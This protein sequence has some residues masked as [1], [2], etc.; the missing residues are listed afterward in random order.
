MTR[1]DRGASLCN[2]YHGSMGSWAA[3]SSSSESDPSQKRLSRAPVVYAQN[4]AM[5]RNKIATQA[6]TMPTIAPVERP[7]PPSSL[8][9]ASEISISLELGPGM[10]MGLETPDIGPEVGASVAGTTGVGTSIGAA[11]GRGGTVGT[12]AA[13]PV[14]G[15]T[16]RVVVG[17]V[18]VVV[19]G[20]GTSTAE[21][22]GQVDL[23]SRSL[24]PV[25]TRSSVQSADPSSQTAF[26]KVTALP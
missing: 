15:R 14:V 10:G 7:E 21:R 4:P 16:G 13:A 2:L 11:V 25:R 20:G 26:F 22:S 5:Q 17:G 18:V 19:G 23:S 9:G 24:G 6:M 12:G 8:A 1:E 3:P